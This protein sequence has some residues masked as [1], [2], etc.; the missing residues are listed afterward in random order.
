MRHSTPRAMPMA[1]MH[2][3]PVTIV[4]VRRV[5]SFPGRHGVRLKARDANM[6][7][8]GRLVFQLATRQ[9]EGANCENR[10]SYAS[11]RTLQPDLDRSLLSC[12]PSFISVFAW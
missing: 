1:R 9:R 7:G 4:P 10:L 5:E 2:F 8:R 6:S 11:S 12:A 3:P